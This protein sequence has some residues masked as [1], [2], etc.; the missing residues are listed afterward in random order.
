MVEY[1]F[2]LLLQIGVDFTDRTMTVDHPETVGRLHPLKLFGHE[3]LVLQKA[4][5]DIARKTDIHATFP[6]IEGRA[7][8]EVALDQFLG[9]NAEVKNCVWNQRDA[10]DV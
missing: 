8:G 4:V 2:N 10:V 6:V 1:K 7:F 9:G 5:K 3:P